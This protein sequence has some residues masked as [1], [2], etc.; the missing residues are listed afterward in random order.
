VSI[1]VVVWL[2]GMTITAPV[3]RFGSC[4]CML[5]KTKV[6]EHPLAS[7]K[8]LKNLLL[9]GIMLKVKANIAEVVMPCNINLK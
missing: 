5:C 8:I 7:S 4:Y 2:P 1:D 6:Q 9:L 3:A